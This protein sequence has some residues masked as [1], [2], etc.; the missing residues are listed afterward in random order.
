MVIVTGTNF[1]A[2]IPSQPPVSPESS[3]VIVC[4]IIANPNV[5]IARNHAFNLTQVKPIRTPITA[6]KK[7]PIT[8]V[9]I[10]GRPK[11]FEI[12]ADT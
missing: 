7:P 10:T 5:T 4:M 1:F 8:I 6:A 11:L 12:I 2:G 3:T 9:K